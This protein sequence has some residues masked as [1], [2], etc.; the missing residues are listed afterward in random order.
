ML[1]CKD[2]IY[3]N[4]DEMID[5]L[6]DLCEIARKAGAVEK[7]IFENGFKAEHKEDG[8]LVTIADKKAEELIINYLEK[9]DPTIPFVGEES[10]AE[11]RIP[12]ISGGKYWLVDPLDGTKSFVN[13][14]G[15]F[16]VNI[17]LMDNFEPVAGIIYIPMRDEMYAAAGLG[18]G[19]MQEAGSLEKIALATRNLPDNGLTVVSGR[20]F[21]NTKKIER[22]LGANKINV[23]EPCSSSIKFCTIARGNADIYP[24]MWPTCEW[25]TGAGDAILRSVGGHILNMSGDTLQYGG[26]E[27][28]FLNPH[29]VAFSAPLLDTVKQGM[30]G[31]EKN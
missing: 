5:L 1:Q 7:D 26:V 28:K 31:L 20:S 8:S 3:N 13:G 12:D 14:A 11:G 17:A 2:M 23:V 30:Q 21:K 6:P 10:V 27:N 29:F 19:F 15:E 16:T 24:R 18:S 9:L 4:N 25:D 22:F